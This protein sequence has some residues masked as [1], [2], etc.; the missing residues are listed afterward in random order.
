METQENCTQTSQNNEKHR[1]ETQRVVIKDDDRQEVIYSCEFEV[2]GI[3]REVSF[4]AYA[5][6]R[7]IKLGVR[8]YCRNTQEGTVKGIIQ[9]HVKSFEAMRLWLKHTGSPTSRI[10]KVVF[11]DLETLEEFS[12]AGFSF[13]EE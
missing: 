3:V 5:V 8:G 11:G 4:A 12:Y 2:F 6:R 7:A 13:R 9:G 1:D 10:D